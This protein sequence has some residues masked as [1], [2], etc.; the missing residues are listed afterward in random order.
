[1]GPLRR[2]QGAHPTRMH[3][4]ETS[5]R[6]GRYSRNS[7]V[8]E[9]QSPLGARETVCGTV[10]RAGGTACRLPCSL[11][12][13]STGGC[14][15]GPING[16]RPTRRPQPPCHQPPSAI[17]APL[18]PCALYCSPLHPASVLRSVL[19]QGRVGT[20]CSGQPGRVLPAGV[21]RPGGGGRWPCAAVPEGPR[22][23][24]RVYGAWGGVGGGGAPCA[25]WSTVLPIPHRHVAG[26]DLASLVY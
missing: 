16:S 14:R 4:R 8:T 1:M 25:G 13:R 18:A 20:L 22:E 12:L 24:G 3:V 17:R 7:G 23:Q 15:S 2:G 6:A 5:G 9:M 11:T 10:Y 21:L 19:L 26:V